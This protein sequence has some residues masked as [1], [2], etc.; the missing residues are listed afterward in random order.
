MREYWLLKFLRLFSHV[1]SVEAELADF[2]V[3]LSRAD[4]EVIRLQT[5]SE[6]LEEQVKQATDRELESR[7]RIIDFFARRWGGT[8]FDT[9]LLPHEAEIPPEP[10]RAKMRPRDLVQQ[11]NRNF[12]KDLMER[13]K[14]PQE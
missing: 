13:V 2:Q 4:D 11:A 6:G 14:Q 5:R 10:I 7:A 1:R 8:I 9:A 12:F 3:R